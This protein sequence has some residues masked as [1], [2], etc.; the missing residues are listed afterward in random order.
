MTLAGLRS[1]AGYALF[2]AAVGF[3]FVMLAGR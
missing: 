2:F 1:L 3:A